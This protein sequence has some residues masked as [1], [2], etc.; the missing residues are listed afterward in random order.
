MVYIYIIKLQQNKWYIGKTTNP[1]YRLEEH[2]DGDGS[3]WTTKYPPIQLEG[4]I[5][6]CD[7]FDEDKYTLKY[8]S[9]Y[10]IANVRGGSFCQIQLSIDNIKTISRMIKGSSNKCYNCGSTDH[11]IDKCPNA[12]G[13]VIV[14]DTNDDMLYFK[15]K[16][17]S[18]CIKLDISGTNKLSLIDILASLKKTDNEWK[19]FKVNDI[20]GLCRAINKCNNLKSIKYWKNSTINYIDFIDGLIYILAEDSNVHDSKV[21]NKQKSCY[22]CGRDGHFEKDCYAKTHIT[23]SLKS[24]DKYNSEY[25]MCNKVFDY[26]EELEQHEKYC[27]RKKYKKITKKPIYKKSTKTYQK[28]W[29][30][31]YCPKRY[32]TQNGA[33]CHE[34]LYCTKNPK[35]KKKNYGNKKKYT[36]KK[37]Y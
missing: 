15:K 21:N 18:E 8:M 30:C 5:P 11:F 17:I 29:K 28:K 35:R 6:D 3:V 19:I 26:Y 33:R 31:S 7:D 22:R 32:D 14:D 36:R 23:K 9:K 4:L 12:K 37:Y 25:D 34:N 24:Y 20:K 16:F 13:H 27:K 10:G 2:F 1:N